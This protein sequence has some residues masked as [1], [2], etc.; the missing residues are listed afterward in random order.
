MEP[1]E[2]PAELRLAE[3]HGLLVADRERT[4]ELVSSLTRNF[5]SIVEAT[6]F[7]AT[8]DEHDPEGSTIAFERSQTSSLLAKA[9]NHLADVDKALARI[10]DGSYGRCERCGEAVSRER[11]L[12]RPAARTCIACAEARPSADTPGH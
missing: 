2:Q 7:T 1:S 3:L 8:D 4:S 6:R 5:T 12:A 11:L 9:N 10:A